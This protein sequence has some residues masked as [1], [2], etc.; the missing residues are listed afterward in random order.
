MYETKAISAIKNLQ[1]MNPF[2][3]FR[4]HTQ[5]GREERHARYRGTARVD[6]LYLKLDGGSQRLS[7]D[8]IERLVKIF[9]N[10][11]CQ[12]LEPANRIAALISQ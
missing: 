5:I 9:A 12:R 10:E 11:G 6:V 8:K 1:E 7:F 2:V 4:K 3:N